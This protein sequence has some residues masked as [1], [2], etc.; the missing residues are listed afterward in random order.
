VLEDLKVSSHPETKTAVAEAV[1]TIESKLA[2]T[3]A[4]QDASPGRSVDVA[5]QDTRTPEQ[6]AKAYVAQEVSRW[7]Q[8]LSERVSP[9]NVEYVWPDSR[10]DPL[11]WLSAMLEV[12]KYL[13]AA[14]TLNDP[15]QGWI[16]DLN[17]SRRDLATAQDLTALQIPVGLFSPRECVAILQTTLFEAGFQFDNMVPA[18]FRTTVSKV[19]PGFVQEAVGDVMRLL[20]VELIEWRQ[21]LVG[22]KFKIRP[23]L[24]VR[25]E[26]GRPS[27]LEYHAEDADGDLLMTDYEFGLLGRNYV[28]RLRQTGLRPARSTEGSSV[29]EPISKRRQYHPPR[30]KDL[31]ASL[32]STLPPSS[33]SRDASVQDDRPSSSLDADTVPSQ[34]GTTD[35]AS[36][37]TTTS[38]S[39]TS[40]NSSSGSSSATL[41]YSAGSHMP[42]AGPM[43]MTAQAGGVDVGG[44][45]GFYIT[46]EPVPERKV[47]VEVDQDDVE[48]KPLLARRHPGRVRP[49]LAGSIETLNGSLR[50]A[51]RTLEVMSSV[52]ADMPVDTTVRPSGPRS[53][54]RRRVVQVAPVVQ[55]C[56]S[57]LDDRV[58]PR[59]QAL[60][61]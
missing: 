26:S 37:A 6:A 49:G 53:I 45:M 14:A 28:L 38:G 15:V 9:P 43:V 61:S 42:Y 50:R 1:Q 25:D 2:S 22:A 47:K 23:G 35:G 10:P 24:N 48:M 60:L 54:D 44:D 58:P 13:S 39:Y 36:Y 56:R 8:V 16:A 30:E 29:G 51:S 46:Q 21:M 5:V 31:L 4:F 34:V 27:I 19:S 57:G 52:L 20:A 11:A 18:W 7:E 33:T 41:G 32:P 3:M 17:L 59:Y 40:R 12:S 55:A